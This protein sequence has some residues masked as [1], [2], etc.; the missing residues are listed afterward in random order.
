MKTRTSAVMN[1]LDLFSARSKN[2]K[3]M[4]NTVSMKVH[5]TTSVYLVFFFSLILQTIWFEIRLCLEFME[6]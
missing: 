4:I 2:Q 1:R 6:A 5:K 3:E